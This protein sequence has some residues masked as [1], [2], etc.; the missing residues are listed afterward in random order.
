MQYPKVKRKRPERKIQSDCESV[1]ACYGLEYVR[2]PDDIF[3]YLMRPQT[4]IQ[5]KNL[6]SDYMKGQPDLV[7][8]DRDRVLLVELKSENGGLSQG[9]RKWGKSNTLHVVRDVETFKTLI[10]QWQEGIDNDSK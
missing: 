9:Q 5:I 1:L 3:T 10:L 4:P 7:I 6:V 2:I 8:I